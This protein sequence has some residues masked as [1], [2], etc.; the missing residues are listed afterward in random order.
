MDEHGPVEESRVR[1]AG[2]ARLSPPGPPG[3][4]SDA[5]R[6]LGECCLHHGN[7][8]PEGLGDPLRRGEDPRRT[9]DRGN[10]DEHV[11]NLLD[12][13]VRLSSRRDVHEVRGRWSVDS[14]ERGDPHHQQRRRIELGAC[15]GDGVDVDQSLEYGC[16]SD[17]HTVPPR[18]RGRH[19][20][21]TACPVASVT[22]ESSD[23]RPERT[24]PFTSESRRTGEASE[25]RCGGTRLT[26]RPYDRRDR[27]VRRHERVPDAGRSA[28]APPTIEGGSVICS[29]DPMDPR[30]TQ[31]LIDQEKAF[32]ITSTAENSTVNWW[33]TY[34]TIEDIR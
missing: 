9:D 20:T 13:H 19:A 23:A 8:V 21:R 33:D 24:S 6:S 4:C 26:S 34:D 14:C 7:G 1:E 10:S 3:T 15:D 12:G 5:G 2:Q 18:Q 32:Q 31:V 11:L 29:G 16:F 17:R 30:P 28:T 25:M 22:R 27:Q